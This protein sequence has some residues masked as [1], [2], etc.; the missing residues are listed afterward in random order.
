[1][2]P[3]FPFRQLSQRW[4]LERLYLVYINGST[5]L[6]FHSYHHQYQEMGHQVVTAQW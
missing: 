2:L 6:S 3:L 5:S 1:M 4:T